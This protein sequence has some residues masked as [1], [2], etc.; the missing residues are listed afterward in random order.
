MI[1]IPIRYIVESI[2]KSIIYTAL[3]INSYKVKSFCT[4]ISRIW[5]YQSLL[6]INK[7]SM[8][9]LVFFT[10][11]EKQLYKA[12]DIS[13]SLRVLFSDLLLMIYMGEFYH[14]I[15]INGCFL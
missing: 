11:I 15:L 3:S 12:Q 4:Y 13:I 7:L 1:L 5:T 14:F 10:K 2:R 9:Y 8:I 6:I